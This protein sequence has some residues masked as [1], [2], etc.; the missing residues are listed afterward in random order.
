M[1]QSELLEMQQFASFWI[2]EP[3][4]LVVQASFAHI[5]HLM[6]EASAVTM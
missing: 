2:P 1:K 3:I 5:V 4:K 6:L